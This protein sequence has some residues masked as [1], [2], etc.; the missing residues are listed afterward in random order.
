VADV[1]AQFRV[2]EAGDPREVERIEQL[3]VDARLEPLEVGLGVRAAAGTGAR[4]GPF[5]ATG[6]SEVA[7][8]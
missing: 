2:R 3:A 7:N 1:V 4:P 6:R 5:C 8:M